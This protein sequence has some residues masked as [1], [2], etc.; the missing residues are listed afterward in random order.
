[1][2]QPTSIKKYVKPAVLDLQRE[3]IRDELAARATFLRLDKNENLHA[4]DDEPF[5]AF[6]QSIRQELVWG[7]PNLKPLYEKIAGHN[8]VGVDQVLVANGSDMAIKA[9]FDACVAPGD[10]IVLHAPSYFMFDIYARLAGADV[11]SVPVDADWVPDLD[12]MIAAVD[13]K[14]RMIVIEDPSGFIGT[15]ITPAQMRDLARQLHER[16]VLLLI[17]EAY[18]YVLADQ[19]AHLPLLR[20]FDNV[21]ISRTMSKAHGLAGALMAEIYKCR[22]LYEV[23]AFSAC[24]AEW[25]LDHP[26]FVEEFRQTVVESKAKIFAK[27]DT[28]G[29]RHR[30]TRGNFVLVHCEA[31]TADDMVAQLADRGIL[32]RRPFTDSKITDWVRISVA[33][34]WATRKFLEAFEKAHGARQGAA[35]LTSEAQA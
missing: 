34:P 8:G 7:Y 3:V 16:G 25:A 17:D 4:F 9:L 22:P 10:R 24:V 28:L 30:D 26:E 33:G 32:V 11:A 13:P 2:T 27:L 35:A 6:K 19:S 12:K 21:L 23:S 5:E 14:T 20:E 1:M 18:L 29:V 31:L 15:A